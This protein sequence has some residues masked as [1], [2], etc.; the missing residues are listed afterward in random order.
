M[1]AEDEA[2]G[3]VEDVGPVVAFVGAQIGNVVVVACGTHEF[4]RLDI[5]GAMCEWD[6]D[7]TG[8]YD[9]AGAPSIDAVPEGSRDGRHEHGA[10]AGIERAELRGADGRASR[11]RWAHAE[12]FPATA[13][14][15]RAS[16]AP[17][18]WLPSIV[19]VRRASLNRKEKYRGFAREVDA[20]F[21]FLVDE[22]GLEEPT[23]EDFIVL[24]VTYEATGYAYCFWTDIRDRV[25]GA[26]IKVGPAPPLGPLR[27]EWPNGLG[28]IVR[29]HGPRRISAKLE[30]VMV[31]LGLATTADWDGS[32]RSPRA[33]FASLETLV[34]WLRQA[35]PLIAA[36]TDK[37][38][39]VQKA[40][41]AERTVAAQVAGERHAGPP[42]GRGPRTREQRR[43]PHRH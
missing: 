27:Q 20:R 4:I 37:E 11:F 9:L 43:R 33:T 14:R 30:W 41:A 31:S 36:T 38:D 15:S 13:R 1:V 6:D 29:Y 26:S 21:R 22:F 23:V 32:A 19:K 7:R 28:T 24:S 25:L 17:P 35:H 18:L 2:Q 34:G 42:T 3:A 40:K 12:P 10:A 16:T 39:L 5:A 8:P